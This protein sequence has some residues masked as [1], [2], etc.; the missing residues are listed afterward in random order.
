MLQLNDDELI[1]F[2]DFIIRSI[3]RAWVEARKI[4]ETLKQI[5]KE[6]KGL[7]DAA[8][9]TA[10]ESATE[11]LT[12]DLELVRADLIRLTGDTEVALPRK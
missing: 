7:K 3:H 12:K 1:L 2:R 11:Q 9:K 5:N 6:L 8:R 4:N 10:L